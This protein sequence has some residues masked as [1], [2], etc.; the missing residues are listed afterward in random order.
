MRVARRFMPRLKTAS[1]AATLAYLRAHTSIPVPIIYA[2]DADPY[3]RLGG[4]WMLMSRVS[5]LFHHLRSGH[6]R[7]TTAFL[8]LHLHACLVSAC[9]IFSCPYTFDPAILRV[10]KG[11]AGMQG[12]HPGSTSASRAKPRRLSACVSAGPLY[13]EISDGLRN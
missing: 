1:E 10:P 6:L 3:N 4:E 11:C 9:V 2:W 12:R 13:K 7:S 8:L 5:I